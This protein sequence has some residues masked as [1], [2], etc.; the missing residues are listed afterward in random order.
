MLEEEQVAEAEAEALEI[1]AKEASAEDAYELLVRL[2]AKI[3]VHRFR[4]ELA[5]RRS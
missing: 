2:S 3:M 1:A 5:D 4:A